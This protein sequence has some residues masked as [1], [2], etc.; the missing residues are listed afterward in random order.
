VIYHARRIPGRAP[1][2]QEFGVGEFGEGGDN[3]LEVNVHPLRIGIGAIQRL[4][5]TPPKPEIHVEKYYICHRR[6]HVCFAPSTASYS[7]YVRLFS[8]A[9]FMLENF[10]GG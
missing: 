3:G 10:V 1:Y 7:Y 4:R 5:K 2:F 6:Q 8:R 9:N